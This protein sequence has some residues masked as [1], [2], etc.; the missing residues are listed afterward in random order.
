MIFKVIDHVPGTFLNL[1]QDQPTLEEN[2]LEALNADNTF[3]N[4]YKNRIVQE[5]DTFNPRQVKQ[6]RGGG[7]TCADSS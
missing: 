5:W 3:K 4:H 7:Q 1:W 6:G 2:S